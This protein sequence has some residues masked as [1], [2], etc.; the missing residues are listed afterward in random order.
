[1]SQRVI[2]S[3]EAT[4]K[5]GFY[6]NF[7]SCVLSDGSIVI[8]GRRFDEVEA[9]F[10]FFTKDGKPTGRM[11]S[12]LCEHFITLLSLIITGMEYLAVSCRDCKKIHLINLQDEDQEPLV[13]YSSQENDIGPMCQG[14]AGTLYTV[15]KYS[16]VVLVFDFTTT[17]FVLKRRLPEIKNFYTLDICYMH[18][19]GLITLCSNAPSRPMSKHMKKIMQLGKLMKVDISDRICTLSTDGHLM[20]DISPEIDDKKIKPKC[21]VYLPNQDLLLVG[22]G[23]NS[24]IIIVTGRTGCIVQTIPV[25]GHVDYL[26]VNGSQLLAHTLEEISFYTVSFGELT[27]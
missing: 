17:S 21:L 27:P 18:R 10:H 8:H 12:Q 11:T 15:G 25:D 20:W 26:H 4:Q 24:R 6:Y 16:G 22:D 19:P 2:L 23:Q 9:K 7:V 14:E 13:A 5:I 3:H 1:M